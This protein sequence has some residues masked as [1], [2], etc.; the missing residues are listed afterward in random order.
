MYERKSVAYCTFVHIIV[1]KMRNERGENDTKIPTDKNIPYKFYNISIL[2]AKL[3]LT[4]ENDI[5]YF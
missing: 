2:S 5:K 4:L 1:F 3:L